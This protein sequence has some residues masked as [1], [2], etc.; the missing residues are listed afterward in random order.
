M[1]YFDWNR[2]FH[3]RDEWDGSHATFDSKEEAD[4]KCAEM[5]AT[6][7]LLHTDEQFRVDDMED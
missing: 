4:A 3:I 7:D 2:R 5:Q 6:A 1:S